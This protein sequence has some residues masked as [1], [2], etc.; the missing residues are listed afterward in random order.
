MAVVGTADPR[1]WPGSV[2][3]PEPFDA[4]ETAAESAVRLRLALPT[5][6]RPSSKARP[7]N[8]SFQ[9]LP[10]RKVLKIFLLGCSAQSYSMA[11]CVSG[12]DMP[13]C[14]ILSL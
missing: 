12:C 4:E 11:S 9:T 2:A 8:E 1:A 6:P 10:W 5:P 13:H 3:V 14:F 7:E